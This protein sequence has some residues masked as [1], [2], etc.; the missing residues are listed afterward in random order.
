MC[1]MAIRRCRATR[2][3]PAA[4]TG[5]T[6]IRRSPPTPRGCKNVTDFVLTKFL[7]RLKALARCEARHG[8]RAIPTTDRMTF[9]DAH[10]AE[11]AKH[12]FCARS[13]AGSG[14]RPR[15]LL[16]RRAKASMPDPVAAAT[17]PLVCD[18][19]PSEFRP[20]APRAR[21]IRTANDSYFTAMT[22]P[23]GLPSTMQPA[24][25]T[26]PP[27]ARCPR[28]MAARSIRAPRATRRW[29]TPR[30]RRCAQALGLS[31]ARSDA[32]SRCRR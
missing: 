18:C 16:R 12:G 6:C 22:F 17:A 23:R 27:G 15:M 29:R 9:V 2:P 10:Q 25:S 3:A 30:C 32:P 28:S 20:Y 11:F 13:D 5:S 21:W 31:A 19:G 1:P 14:V 24:T 7:P 4:A 8:L 26:T